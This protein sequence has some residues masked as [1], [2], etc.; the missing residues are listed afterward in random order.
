MRIILGWISDTQLVFGKCSI[1]HNIIKCETFC[2]L[3]TTDVE[4]N[5]TIYLTEAK[6][7]RHEA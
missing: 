5:I 4:E 2:L 7:I 1:S 6:E 3:I